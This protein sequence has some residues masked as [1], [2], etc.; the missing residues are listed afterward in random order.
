MP[1]K[2][3]QRT[4]KDTSVATQ[5]NE[6][7][8]EP[9]ETESSAAQEYATSDKG[10]DEGGSSPKL[11]DAG[12]PRSALSWRDDNEDDED[13]DE[14]DEDDLYGKGFDAE[15]KAG[16]VLEP[17]RDHPEHKWCIMWEGFKM[18]M[19]YVRRSKYCC[20]DLFDMYITNDFEGYGY[21]ELIEN[22]MGVVAFDG[23]LKKKD[24]DALKRTWAIVSALSLWLNEVN[25]RPLMGNENGE[26][27]QAII[28]L[29]GYTLLR[30]LA[31]LDFEGQVKPDTDF[32]DVPIVITSL[33]EFSD[34]LEDYGI[35]A[36]AL[37]WR[38]HAAAYFKKGGFAIEKGVFAAKKVLESANGGSEASLAKKGK[39][40]WG[41]DKLVKKYT[42]TFCTGKM[43]GTKYDITKMSRKERAGHAFDH[44]NPLADISDKDL[45]EGVLDFA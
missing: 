6:N 4:G 2:K 9:R 27:T 31:A 18:C 41:W 40:P 12:S 14:D 36:E 39:D 23:S 25:Q 3:K 1:P 38:P 37:E 22:F 34:S 44:K 8:E 20:P 29:I 11:R 16:V 42:R 33:L 10:S 15:E 21:Q 13:E 24:E 43:G 5:Q 26:K 19:D 28:E 35:D 7:Q 45:K 17:S 30:G 32:L